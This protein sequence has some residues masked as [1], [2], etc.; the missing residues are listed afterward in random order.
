MLDCHSIVG[1]YTYQNRV[2]LA[3][4]LQWV[5]CTERDRVPH[6]GANFHSSVAHS[7]V[8]I[9]TIMKC[10][11]LLFRYCGNPSSKYTSGRM[12]SSPLRFPRFSRRYRWRA[13]TTWSFSFRCW[14]RVPLPKVQP[15]LSSARPSVLTLKWG[16]PPSAFRDSANISSVICEP[17]RFA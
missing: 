2:P 17:S 14:E 4:S 16:S 11:S 9:R 15:H 6:Q 7:Q 8:S 1:L 12:T 5:S 10:L 3:P 13:A